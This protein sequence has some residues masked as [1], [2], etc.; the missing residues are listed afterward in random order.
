MTNSVPSTDQ[1]PVDDSAVFE[2]RVG[3][4]TVVEPVPSAV[5]AVTDARVPATP[6]EPVVT[7]EERE[8]LPPL[9][10]VIGTETVRVRDQPSPTDSGD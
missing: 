2:R 9:S 4:R 6:E 1:P 7:D 3:D 8:P 5:S 10:E